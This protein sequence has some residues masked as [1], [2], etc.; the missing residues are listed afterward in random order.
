MLSLHE[1]F[2]F[3]IHIKKKFIQSA[4]NLF[5]SLINSNF[6]TLFVNLSLIEDIFQEAE[7]S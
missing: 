7:I 1:S 5:F 3:T 6:L 4:E 2:N